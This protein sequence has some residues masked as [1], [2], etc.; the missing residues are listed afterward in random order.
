MESHAHAFKLRDCAFIPVA[1]GLRAQTLSELRD[2]LTTIPAASIYFHF[3]GRFLAAEFKNTEYHN[4]FAFWAHNA[5]HDEFLAERLSIL[6]PSDYENIELLRDDLIDIV[7]TRLDELEY[8]PIAKRE[9]QFH[10]VLS[11]MIVFDTVHLINHP[12]E[13]I[14][15]IESAPNTSIFYHVID[16]RARNPDSSDD[17][18]NWLKAFGDEYR[19][20]ID[21][22]QKIDPYFLNMHD[23]KKQYIRVITN[24]FVK[25]A[26]VLQ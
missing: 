22:L 24:F 20:L 12:H 9:N 16:A 2:R 14:R 19:P 18:S 4:D 3:W 6:D 7:S 5:L 15:I 25:N 17:F 11:K 13:L 10:F 21:D 1:T 26:E 23:L 8:L